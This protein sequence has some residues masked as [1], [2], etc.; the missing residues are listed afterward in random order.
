MSILLATGGPTYFRIYSDRIQA[1]GLPVS[2]LF[3]TQRYDLLEMVDIVK[4]KILVLHDWLL[5][6]YLYSRMEQDYE[7]LYLIRQINIKYNFSI[8]LIYI[9]QRESD[10]V[11]LSHLKKEQVHDVINQPQDILEALINLLKSKEALPEIERGRQEKH[12]SKLQQLL[13]GRVKFGY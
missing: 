5:K 1:E 10:D 8:R 2:P 11:F 7:I 6:S 13:R 4:P 9:C 12:E 3:V